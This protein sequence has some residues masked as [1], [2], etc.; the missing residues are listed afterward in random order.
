MPFTSY[1]VDNTV[2]TLVSNGKE[3]DI[4][5]DIHGYSPQRIANAFRKEH[6]RKAALEQATVSTPPTE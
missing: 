1:T 6:L 3:L 4:V 5:Y 2:V